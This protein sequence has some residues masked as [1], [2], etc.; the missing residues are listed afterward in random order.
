MTFSVCGTLFANGGCPPRDL[1]GCTLPH[2]HAGPHEFIDDKDERY[3]WET[4]L[5]CT[6]EICAAEDGENCSR[7]WRA[8]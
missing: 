4:D 6:C 7:Y 2:G 8:K 3:Q 5:A 1:H